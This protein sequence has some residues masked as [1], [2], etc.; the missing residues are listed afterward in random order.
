VLSGNRTQD[1]K[2]PLA[3]QGGG[4]S[5]RRSLSAKPT[6]AWSRAGGRRSLAAA[7]ALALCG[8]LGIGAAVPAPSLQNPIVVDAMLYPWSTLGRV[9]T[10]GQGH[11]TGVLI[12][13]LHVL[14]RAHCLY[15]ATE[16][17]WWSPSD[18]HF[19]AGYQRDS[20]RVH[21]GVRRIHVAPRYKGGRAVLAN[22][23]HDWAVL[24]LFRP[25]GREAGW[26]GLQRHGRSTVARLERGE[27]YFLRSGGAYRKPCLWSSA[28]VGLAKLIFFD[29]EVRALMPRAMPTEIAGHNLGA[30]RPRAALPQASGF[31]RRQSPAAIL[32]L[33][34][35]AGFT[36]S[37]TLAQQ[38]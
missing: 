17:R 3:V 8:A 23:E 22:L 28:G 27:A 6:G 35:R 29:G 9:N 18:L 25:I 30:T 38:D 4:C 19:V 12:S 10:G 31:A 32:R 33:L 26:I 36:D 1:R 20:Y 2:R 7:A 11:C 21:S 14:T 37:K 5:A 24:W 13:E 16:G 34:R 15:N